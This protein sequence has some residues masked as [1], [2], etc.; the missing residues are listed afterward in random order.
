MLINERVKLSRFLSE[1]AHALDIPDYAYHEAVTKYEDIGEYLGA[2]DSSLCHYLPKIYPQGSFRLGTVV[3]PI[4][5]DQGFDIDL[6]CV[7]G[8]LKE[9]ITQE[10]LKR[11]IGDRLKQRDDLKQILKP[12]RRCWVLN[13]PSEYEMPDF[14]MDVL[15]SIP[16][17]ER[18]P[19][20]ILLS[21]TKLVKWQKSNPIAY[22]NWFKSRMKESFDRQKVAF[23]ESYKLDIEEVPDWKIKTPLQTAVQLLKR[24]RDTYFGASDDKPVSVILTTLAAIAYEGHGDVYDTLESITR[25]MP[26]N[27]ENRKGSW[28]VQNPVDPDEN[29]ADKWNEYPERERLFREW[30]GKVQADFKGV[31]EARSISAGL[32]V[33]TE[34]IGPHTMTKV[35]S[36]F[37]LT[38]TAISTPTTSKAIIPKLADSSHAVTPR[39]HQTRMCSVEVRCGVYSR[40]KD[41]SIGCFIKPLGI[42]TVPKGVWLKFSTK[43]NAKKPYSVFW[44]VVNTGKEAQEDNCLRGQINTRASKIVL[45][46]STKYRG[47]HWVEAFVIRNRICVGRSGPIYVKVR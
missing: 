47:V 45:K 32:D 33:L 17:I 26:E 34:S 44:Q 36:A 3:R 18:H 46:E 28:W 11:R 7:L 9:S 25:R 13:Y 1:T 35:A 27:I 6:V 43:T 24:H 42:G 15:P 31:G 29:F 30:L 2:G 23:A 39:W 37:G 19:T 40:L 10:E 21:D 20:G 12:S 14:H 22:S 38:Q 16:N 4:S 8:I 5:S 41:G